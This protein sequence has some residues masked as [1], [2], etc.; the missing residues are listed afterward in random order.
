MTDKPII[1]EFDPRWMLLKRRKPTDGIGIVAVFLGKRGS[2]KTTLMIDLLKHLNLSA[3]MAVSPTERY[4]Q[5]FSPI[6]PKKYIYGEFKPQ[7]LNRLFEKQ[8]KQKGQP[9]SET[10][11]VLDDCLAL[12]NWQKSEE[13]RQLFFNGRHMDIFMFLS[14]QSVKGLN[15]DFRDQCD[16]WFLGRGWGGESLKKIYNEHVDTYDSFKLF[17]QHYKDAVSDNGFLVISKHAKSNGV[18]YY[19]AKHWNNLRL[20]HEIYWSYSDKTTQELEQGDLQEHKSFMLRK[21]RRTARVSPSV[22]SGSARSAR[23]VRSSRTVVSDDGS[24]EDFY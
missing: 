17:Q 24:S 2:G 1:D 23:S 20:C 16:F 13:M 8:M 22:A 14:I 4:N 3:G 7:I 12:T 9:G 11:L 21:A 15:N 5:D 18:Y 10:F 19:K 6:M